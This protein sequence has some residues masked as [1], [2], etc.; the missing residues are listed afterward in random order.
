[1]L[2]HAEDE[3]IQRL[4][5]LRV[6]QGGRNQQIGSDQATQPMPLHHLQLLLLAPH[7]SPPSFRHL[8]G[9]RLRQVPSIG[10]PRSRPITDDGRTH[11]PNAAGHFS[12]LAAGPRHQGQDDGNQQGQ[13]SQG[14]I[15]WFGFH[16]G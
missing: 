7:Q 4:A 10:K 8:G 14:M 16:G 11:F 6:I 13:D 2:P 9:R 12:R 1:M 5:L 3:G 15:R